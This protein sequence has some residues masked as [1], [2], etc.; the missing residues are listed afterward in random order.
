[1]IAWDR[2]DELKS[3]IGEDDFLEIVA[4][5]LDETEAALTRL[6]ETADPDEAEALLHF[7]KGSA[8]NLGFRA[9]GRLCRDR[10]PPLHDTEVWPFELAE[11]RNIYEVSK[12]HLLAAHDNDAARAAASG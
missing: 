5:F 11:V 1:M 8:L 6:G 10:R 7:L 2:I 9:L 3:E 4:L 12:A